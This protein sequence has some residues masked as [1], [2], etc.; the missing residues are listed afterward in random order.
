MLGNQSNG[1]YFNKLN[2]RLLQ[3]S[4]DLEETFF[5]FSIVVHILYRVHRKGFI[6]IIIITLCIRNLIILAIMCTSLRYIKI[7]SKITYA[8]IHD[9]SVS[10]V[11]LIWPYDCHIAP[12]TKA[13][14][15]TLIFL[16]RTFH[17]VYA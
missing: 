4:C 5:F 11:Q 2:N 1:K 14:T 13:T 10:F 9:F 16:K 7:S 12:G 8:H 3:A 15:L 17:Y 6:L